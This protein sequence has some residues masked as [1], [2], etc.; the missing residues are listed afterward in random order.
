MPL[1]HHTLLLSLEG[2]LLAFGNNNE[3]QLGLGHM[4][5]QWQP[6][7]VPWS[8]PQPVQVDWGWEH[9]LALDVEGGVWGAGRYSRS[10]PPSSTFQRVLGLPCV[11]MVAAG[12]SHSAAVDIEGG[13]WVW[14]SERDLHWSSSLPQRVEGLPPL[15]KVTCGS[16]F[17]VAEAEEGTL[18]FLHNSYKHLQRTLPTLLQV[19]DQSEGP[20]R[21]LVALYEGVILIDSQG[22]VF[23]SR[24]NSLNQ[25]RRSSEGESDSKLERI[26]NI[27]PMLAASC[28]FDHTLCLDE[29]GGVWTW[30]FGGSGR[31]GTNNTSDA[32]NQS[33][34]TLVPSLKG[35]SALVAGRSHSLAFPQEGGLLVFGWNKYGQLGLNHTTEKLTPTLCPVQPAL[36]RSVISRKK[37]A[38]FL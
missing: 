30:G 34:P 9:S 13:L 5:H 4:D 32:S 38:R 20:L 3:G 31:L 21:C 22:D 12:N 24:S 15:V 19:K 28:G 11:T 26:M 37:S 29:D 17:L 8:G 14:T 10:S 2:G 1:G 7:E 18:W 33:P 36:P 35:I 16:D 27:P 6:I 25:L 23:T